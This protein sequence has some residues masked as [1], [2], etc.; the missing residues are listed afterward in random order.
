MD[1]DQESIRTWYSAKTKKAIRCLIA[2]GVIS[3]IMG[4]V[5]FV[6]LPQDWTLQ[7]QIFNGA[8]S[9]PLG[10]LIWIVVFTLVWMVPIREIS[11]RTFESTEALRK[12]LRE[13][14]GDNEIR[15]A[16]KSFR[17][18]FE[19]LEERLTDDLLDRLEEA[20]DSMAFSKETLPIPKS[21][22]G[23]GEEKKKEEEEVAK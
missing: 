4:F 6:A 15:P 22:A 14:T 2:F 18:V 9:I 7:L 8:Y 21:P 13:V 5:L 11:F 17:R 12:E 16:L 1:K 20:I 3:T 19:K 10:A 23:N